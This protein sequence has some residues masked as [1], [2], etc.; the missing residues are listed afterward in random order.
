M[1][2][3]H[4]SLLVLPLIANA[5]PTHPQLGHRSY[6]GYKIFRVTPENATFI[7]PHLQSLAAVEMSNTHGSTGR[8]IID[9]AIPPSQIDAFNALGLVT[10]ILSEDLGA[11]IAL[12]GKLTPFPGFET[13]SL[14]AA[15][16]PALPKASWFKHY[17]P[18]ADHLTFL[19]GL[20]QA[21]PS[22]SEIVTA[23]T[24]WENRP[25]RGIH[26]WGSGDPNSKPAIIFHGNTVEYIAYQLI[27]TY[28]NND[29]VVQ[30]VLDNHD[31]YIFPIVNPDGFNYTQTNDRLWRK[32]RQRRYGLSA[33]GT[34]PYRNWPYQWDGVGS[35][36]DP[37]SDSYRGQQP[38]DTP[39]TQGLQ[40]HGDHLSATQG[41]KL[42]IDFH[43]YGQHILTPYGYSCTAEP[44]NRV[45][46]NSLAEDMVAA[47]HGAHG[48]RFTAGPLCSSLYT[49]AGSSND[50]FTDVAAAQY[51][52][53]I[54]LRGRPKFTLPPSEILP[55]GEE[56][57]AGLKAL[58]E[59]FQY[60]GH[61]KK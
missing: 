61:S 31:F 41:I 46:Q 23:G 45:D 47:M 42:Y 37:E 19:K 57:W 25:I 17:H 58:W 18:D 5:T 59:N 3:L 33:V 60:E 55:S 48:K 10:E 52:W 36:G 7:R 26:I 24:S 32:N 1:K 54:E 8:Q 16:G 27:N 9:V 20:Q 43:S 2:F 40:S 28:R 22:N 39:E 50:Y 34:D 51:S 53:V 4:L 38:A 13:D 6:K 12:E 11:D 35:S 29:T 15:T 56:T 49:V 21:F 44:A 14:S 30:A